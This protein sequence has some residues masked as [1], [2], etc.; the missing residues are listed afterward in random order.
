MDITCNLPVK[1]TVFT[2]LLILGGCTTTA[3]MDLHSLNHFKVNC[4]K[5]QEQLDFLYSQWPSR[6]EQIVNSLMIRSTAGFI[7]SNADDTYQERRY[8]DE[9]RYTAVLRMTIDDVKRSCPD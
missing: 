5:K 2:S 9:G 3:R 4:A 1:Y 6:D 8:M 7:F